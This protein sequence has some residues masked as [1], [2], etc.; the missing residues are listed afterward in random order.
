LELRFDA[1]VGVALGDVL[2]GEAGSRKPAMSV[3][4]R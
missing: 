4:T 1:L 2:G 3:R